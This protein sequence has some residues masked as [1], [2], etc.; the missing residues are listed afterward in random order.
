MRTSEGIDLHVGRLDLGH[1]R[2]RRGGGVDA[3]LRLGRGHALHA[4]AAGLELELRIGAVADDARDHFLVA[5]GVA[6]ALG[7]DLHLPAVALGEARVH[8]E[9]VAREERA[10]VAARARADF[11]EEVALVV[12][13][14]R[15]EH[16]LH[17]RFEGGE[18]LAARANL[19][20]GEFPHVGVLRHL[21]G[22]GDVALG[23][24]IFGEE[25]DHRLDL[26]A[27]LRE[28]LEALHVLRGVRVGKPR[29]DLTQAP[30]EARELGGDRWLHGSG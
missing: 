15:Q 19:V 20:L 4:M 11:E 24:P 29:I 23:F 16:P 7:D 9:E 14:A 27:L 10:L 13:I 25:L 30:L 6:R 12:G 8:A 22:G 18:A 17:L 5:A 3:S 1:H 26:G 21:L 2:D 28:L